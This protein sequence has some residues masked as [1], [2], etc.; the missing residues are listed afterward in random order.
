MGEIAPRGHGLGTD[1]CL[2]SGSS[3]PAGH[4]THGIYGPCMPANVPMSFYDQAPDQ[5]FLIHGRVHKY[6]RLSHNKTQHAIVLEV[7]LPGVPNF[8]VVNQHGPFSVSARN[9]F[10]AWFT[11]LTTPAVLSG[12]FNDAILPN[13]PPRRRTW[14]DHLQNALLYHPLYRITP[15]PTSPTHTRGGKRLDAFL[16]PTALWE[17]LNPTSYHVQAFPSE[18]DHAGVFMHTNITLATVEPP[19][20]SI[21]NIRHWGGRDLKKFRAHFTRWM[22]ELLPD[23]PLHG[24]LS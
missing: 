6:C 9:A 22:R 18:G 4:R 11:S 12:N 14:H 8:L 24:Q 16:V 13:P 2:S 1:D 15:L 19:D 20:R 21:P 23:L 3:F 10:D 7:A 17:I 5:V